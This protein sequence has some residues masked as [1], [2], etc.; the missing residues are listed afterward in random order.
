[1]HKSPIVRKKTSD[2]LKTRFSKEDIKKVYKFRDIIGRGK[3]GCVRVG[4]HY[5]SS[6]LG[7]KMA[8]KSIFRDSIEDSIAL[9]ELEHDIMREADHPNIAR[10]YETFM[11]KYY[12]HFVMELCE[13]GDLFEMI[14]AKERFFEPEAA[15]IIEQI[16][17]ALAHCQ[18]RGICHR[19]LKPENIVFVKKATNSYKL[20]LIQG[21]ADIKIIDFGLARYTR[22]G[23]RLNS[24]VGTPYYVAPD[25]LAGNY[26]YRCDNWSVGVIAYTLLAGYP[27]FFA[28]SHSQVF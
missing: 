28:E 8:I 11:D 9:V 14:R 24:K 10:I 13:G 6:Y 21:E 4:Q 2:N 22:N 18:H 19:D 23:Q 16:L 17:L 3:F 27:P 1:M 25:V 12:Y 20:D 7:R 5:Q 26:D 15:C